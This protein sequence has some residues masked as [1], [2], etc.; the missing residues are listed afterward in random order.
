[1]SS[2]TKIAVC[3]FGCITSPKYCLQV[4]KIQ[5][6]WGKRA[7]EKHEVPV[8]YFL[9]EERMPGL[10]HPELWR[11]STRLVYLPGVGNDYQSASFKQNLGIKYIL[12][13]HP[14][15]EFVFVCGTDTFL[16]IDALLRLVSYMNPDEKLYIGGHYGTIPL[17]NLPDVARQHGDDICSASYSSELLRSSEEYA[18]ISSA[19]PRIP[20]PYKDTK[21]VYFHL[22]GA[23]FVLSRG[24]LK[25]LYPRLDTMTEPWIESC[26]KMDKEQYTGACDVCIAYHAQLLGAKIVEYYYRFYECNHTGIIDISKMYG[27]SRYYPCCQNHLQ[28]SNV[29]SSHNMS[30][31][32]FDSFYRTLN[33]NEWFCS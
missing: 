17:T 13:H 26:K 27:Y 22:G 8:Y 33:E 19:S 2:V 9:G 29:V 12:D 32:D 5:E 30:L 7:E 23:G 6:T 10:D 11:P 14:E 16:N 25:E 24:I 3:V 15:V 31:K 28:T 21:E 1:M 18:C 20:H 4:L